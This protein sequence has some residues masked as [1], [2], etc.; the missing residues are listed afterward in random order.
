MAFDELD[1]SDLNHYRLHV[2]RVDEYCNFIDENCILIVNG[3]HLKNSKLREKI[4]NLAGVIGG[5][6]SKNR[7]LKIEINKLKRRIKR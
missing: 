2:R 4:G 5:L 3:L 1:I 7:S 6:K